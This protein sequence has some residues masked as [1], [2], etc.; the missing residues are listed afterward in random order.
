MIK[1][2]M[3]L[4]CLDLGCLSDKKTGDVGVSDPLEFSSSPSKSRKVHIS[5]SISDLIFI[6]VNGFCL[7]FRVTL[8]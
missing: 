2:A 7:L 1:A 8:N 5:V 6:L 3:D 4:G